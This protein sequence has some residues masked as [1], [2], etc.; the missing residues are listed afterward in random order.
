[1]RNRGIHSGALS[2][3]VEVIEL[4]VLE[5]RLRESRLHRSNALRVNLVADREWVDPIEVIVQIDVVSA[6]WLFDDSD[7]VGDV[8]LWGNGGLINT[9]SKKMP[10]S[11]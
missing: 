4:V 10:T 5:L 11:L 7:V 9:E 2:S 6:R 1:M 8:R 3:S